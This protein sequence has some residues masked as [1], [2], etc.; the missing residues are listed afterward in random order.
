MEFRV[1]VKMDNAAFENS[2]E[3]PRI[4]EEIA[5]Q[6]R[7][8]NTGKQIADSNG[9]RVGQWVIDPGAE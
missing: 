3:L 5:R 8:G 2:E 7:L 4:L 9:N 1:N 6:L